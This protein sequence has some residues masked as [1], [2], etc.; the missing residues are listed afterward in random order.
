[1]PQKLNKNIVWV[2]SYPKS[3][4]TWVRSILY[5]AARGR[6]DLND[7]GTLIPSFPACI[8]RVAADRNISHTDDPITLWDDTQRWISSLGGNRV[9]KTHNL[10]GGIGG[11]RFPK[12][13]VTA[14]AIYVVRDPRDVAMS[15]CN[16]YGRTV[17]QAAALLQMDDNVIFMDKNAFQ[18]SVI[19]SWNTHVQSW[20][21]ADFPV[22]FVRYED[23]TAAPATEIKRILDFLKLRPAIP[24]EQIAAATSFT[25][26][27]QQESV[28][29]FAEASD[30]A[31]RFFHKGSVG[32][33]LGHENDLQE[34]TAA[35]APLMEKFGYLDGA[36]HTS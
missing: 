28:D 15:Y 2:A 29:G 22:L 7:V 14:G 3:G 13:D 27:A 20:L 17:E 16:H 19:G 32:Q 35:F 21:N 11:T 6:M 30:N 33:W 8:E 36:R 34:L 5:C 4:N 12:P 31:V 25:E 24:P 1:M 18:K 10:C 23:L 26:M 9:I